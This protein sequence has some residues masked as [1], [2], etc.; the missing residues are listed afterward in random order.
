MALDEV[1]EIDAVDL[2]ADLTHELAGLHVVVGVLED[3]ADH[4]DKGEEVSF[5]KGRIIVRGKLVT[6][7][8]ATTCAPPPPR[9]KAA[10]GRKLPCDA[11]R[12]DY[13]EAYREKPVA[14]ETQSPRCGI[15]GLIQ[16][17]SI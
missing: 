2:V 6:R 5:T 7:G 11:V 10:A 8:K 12:F 17:D 14:I 13:T 15:R 9:R 4:T 16:R 3:F 1:V